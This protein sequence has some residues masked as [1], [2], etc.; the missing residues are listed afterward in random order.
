MITTEGTSTKFFDLTS[1]F[2]GCLVAS[3]TGLVAQGCTIEYIGVRTDGVVVSKTCVFSSLATKLA[4]CDKFPTGF[5]GLKSVK[6]VP[7][8]ADLL[9]ATTVV[10]IDTV[11]GST[12]A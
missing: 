3:Q 9:P 4:A 10:V 6:V 8:R 1:L 12:Y 7:V 2:N 11:S 5:K